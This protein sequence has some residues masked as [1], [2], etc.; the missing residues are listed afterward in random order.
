V[1]AEL[2]DQLLAQERELD[3]REGTIIMWEESLSTFARVLREACTGRDASHALGGTIRCD[4]LAQVSASSSQ[5][6]RHKALRRMLD[7]R[8]I[9]LGLQE[10]DLGVR[11][12]ILAEELEH[13][14]RDP[15]GHDLP[16]E[17]D[18]TRA[19]GAR[20]CR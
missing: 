20:D 12:A 15:D 19:R 7:E 9:L 13:G 8:V 6:K 17:L 10:T 11:E 16:A 14:L 4:Y 1:I 18:K 5:S 2:Q 3:S